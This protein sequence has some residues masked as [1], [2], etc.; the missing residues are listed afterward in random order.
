VH[1]GKRKGAISPTSHGHSSRSPQKREEGE[2]RGRGLNAVNVVGKKR[3]IVVEENRVEKMVQAKKVDGKQLREAEETIMEAVEK[4]REPPSKDLRR[5]APPTTIYGAP[6]LSK[7]AMAFSRAFE[8]M[9]LSTLEAVDRI[10]EVERVRENWKRRAAHVARMKSEREKRCQKVHDIRQK[11]KDT[12][13]A[14]RIMEENKLTILRDKAAKEE[15]RSMLDRSLQRS[16]VNE[17][18]MKEDIERSFAAKFTRQSVSIAREVSKDDR[19][20]STEERREEIK[21]Q[22]RELTE[23][24]R[25]RR[26]EAQAERE[27]R[28]TQLVWEGALEKKELSSKAMETA[29]QSMSEAKRRVGRAV[30]RR[31]AARASMERAREALRNN[32]RSTTIPGVLPALK[33]DLRPEPEL[34]EA[35]RD[36]LQAV[37]AEST[38]APFR[39]RRFTHE[40][41]RSWQRGTLVLAG[42]ERLGTVPAMH[43]HRAPASFFPNIDEASR[44]YPQQLRPGPILHSFAAPTPL[45]SEMSELSPVESP[46]AELCDC[47]MT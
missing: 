1:Q 46:S 42:R 39:L 33:L 24:A 44:T 31:A 23:A 15:M 30:N 3:E 41:N 22:V 10:H 14:W 32:S 17:N 35:G 27:I 8:S 5:I 6:S 11:T 26:Q 12:I 20:I 28:R 37:T 9:T 45:R 36:T 7:D 18:K 40:A 16:V 13:E 21:K 34:A 19:E 4:S 38:S 47:G 43:P 2:T 29:I 25:Q